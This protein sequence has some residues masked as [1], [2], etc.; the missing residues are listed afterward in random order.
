[1]FAGRFC[2]VAPSRVRIRLALWSTLPT[3]SI[4]RAGSSPIV[5]PSLS[6]S[7]R[8]LRAVLRI[9]RMSLVGPPRPLHPYDDQP[10]GL[11]HARLDPRQPGCRTLCHAPSWSPSR[12]LEIGAS[13]PPLFERLLA[14]TSLEHR[15]VHLC[16]APLFSG[17]RSGRFTASR[18]TFY[19]GAVDVPWLLAG[20]FRSP[21][22]TFHDA[23]MDVARRHG[24]RSTAHL[25]AA[26]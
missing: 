14:P 10:A 20:R 6:R 13:G 26:W 16:M 11:L 25:V 19:D 8:R 4:S 9:S 2:S 12:L 17:L 15:Q 7:M 24:G 3:P 5:R 1:M 22:W 23:L 18:W 21:G